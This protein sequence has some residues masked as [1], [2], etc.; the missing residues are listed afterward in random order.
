MESLHLSHA[1]GVVRFD[2]GSDI[3][4]ES[5]FL[6]Y[7]KG[8]TRVVLITD[9]HVQKLYADHV[10][11]ALE[12]QGCDVLLI[13][14][15]PGE[16]SKTREQKHSIEDQM[17]EAGCGRDIL[18]IALGG[19]V[20]SD[21]AGFIASTYARGVA[22][23]YIPTTLLAMVDAAIG[24]KTGVNTAHG[25][26]LIGTFYQ[27]QRVFCDLKMFSTLSHDEMANGLV[28]SV[29][30]ALIWDA[31]Y[32]IEVDALLDDFYQ[33]KELL[34]D[35]LLSL[36]LRSCQIKIEV[37][38]QDETEQGGVRQILNFGHSV[39]H[40]LERELGYQISHGQAVLMGLWVESFCSFERGFLSMGDF[41][42]IKR[43]LAKISFS[44]V[45]DFKSLSLDALY[46][47]MRLDKKALARQPRFVLLDRLG[48][49]R[50][51]EGRFSFGVEKA[52]VLRGLKAWEGL[53]LAN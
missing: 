2:I 6:A 8:F 36:V 50:S 15:E 11:K 5:D 37:V 3:L 32:F 13:S 18:M 40:A 48:Q 47:A 30:H 17:L 26:N 14:I 4:V 33:G 22:L 24:G 52:L 35:D 49:A 31:D 43:A 25:K 20:V 10:V 53:C 1:S 28:E 34:Q 41:N 39:A 27:P 44:K 12:G 42:R 21:L 45:I 29:K 19:G 46:E 38:E 23:C 51:F 16:S 7:V 9:H